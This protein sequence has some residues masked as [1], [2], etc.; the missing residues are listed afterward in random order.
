[1]SRDDHFDMITDADAFHA[2][3]DQIRQADV[4]GVDTEFVSEDSYDP[5]LCLIQVKVGDRLALIDPLQIPDVSAFWQA[6]V[7]APVETVIHGGREELLFCLRATGRRPH[8]L[9]DLQVAAGL[10]G[11]AYPIGY[12]NLCKKVLDIDPGKGEQRTDWRRRPL[13]Q[14]QLRYA[15]EDVRHLHALREYL[16][17][18]LDARDRLPWLDAEMEAWQH[19]IEREAGRERWQRVK[20]SNG[21][22]PKQLA[23]LRGLWRWREAAGKQR[24]VRPKRVL[25]DDL[26]CALAR[27]AS[28]DEEQMRRIR[29]FERPDLRRLIP[30]MQRAIGEA[31][32]LDPSEWPRPSAA[33]ERD[34]PKVDL[35]C[36]LMVLGMHHA[37]QQAEVAPSLVASHKDLRKMVR[38]RLAATSAQAETNQGADDEED[39]L[40]LLSGWRAEVVGEPLAALLAGRVSV[41]IANLQAENPLVFEPLPA[42]IDG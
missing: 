29:G 6:L 36:Q 24:D 27:R 11:L 19:D 4:V 15:A 34:D 32:D 10:L 12:A 8:R 41:R 14:H 20:G 35:L 26:L 7:E 25:R 42:S 21:L 18:E 38:E 23:V 16:R 39:S 30:A 40:P 37:C 22:K 5:E 3:C 13:S 33:P 31:L 1:M 9:L 28:K 17:R 2:L